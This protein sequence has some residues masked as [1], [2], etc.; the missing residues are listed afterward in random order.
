MS[1][2]PSASNTPEFESARQA[3][4]EALE[5][6]AATSAILSAISDTPNDLQPVFDRIANSA[7]R[8]CRGEF[9]AVFRFDGEMMTLVA[10]YGASPVQVDAWSR[11]FPR[12]PGRDLAIGRAI[13]SREVAAIPDVA[14]DAAFA[15]TY[16]ELANLLNFNSVVAV[17]MLLKGLPIGGIVVTRF[18]K[19]PFP[20]NQIALLKTFAEQAVITI[21]S[22]RLYQELEARTVELTRSVERLTALGEVGRAVTSTLDLEKVL[23]TI[24]S[25]A[26][27]LS[28][29]NSG[30]I[31][32]YDETTE[33]FRV[34]ATYL[35]TPEHLEL[36]QQA[37]IRLGEGAIGRAGLTQEPVEI[38]DTQGT[39]KL[40]A[41]QVRE[42]H[43]REGLR[44][45]FALPLVREEQLLGGLVILRREIREF[46]PEVVGLLRTFADQSVLALHN[47]RLFEK[48]QE[49]N[50]GLSVALAYQTATTGVLRLIASSPGELQPVF[51]RIAESAAQLCRGEFSTVFRFD[52]EIITLVAHHGI[53]PEQVDAWRRTF[54]RPPGRDLAIGRAILT[55]EVAT[56]PNVAEDK[57]LAA[58]Y[59]ELASFVKYRSIV[60]VPMLLKGSPIGGIVVARLEAGPFP[61]NQIDL[62]RT[63][64]D[65][66]VIAIE[67]VRLFREVNRQLEIIRAVFGKYVPDSVA[68]AIVSGEGQLKPIKTT[69]T[70]LFSD[71]ES[72]TSIS[73]DLSPEQVV[74][75]L[76]EY[77][78]TVIEPIR[79]HGGVV[80]QFQGDAM[81]VTFNVPVEDSHHADQAV[82]AAFEIQQLLEGRRFAGIPLRARIGITTGTVVAGNVGSGDRVNY[83]VHGDTVNIAARLEQL[84]KEYRT[85]VLVSGETVSLLTG[86]YPLELIGNASI[87]G[88]QKSIQLYKLGV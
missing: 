39:Q 20:D 26:V 31:Y 77:F 44:S 40:V 64:A 41:P 10:H 45:L 75:M 46:S 5:Q 56:I 32:E 88:K 23:D 81:L 72:F 19:G 30:I 68:E 63:F 79:R 13:L 48:A 18:E 49:S 14:A 33:T 29:S 6:Q 65:Q 24:V 52:G 70:V 83:T 17:P 78:P 76:N 85:R 69:A 9:S 34:R 80:N 36:L 25:R 58:T 4:D 60:A 51:D 15:E 84:N 35:V 42:Q 67:S 61:G 47:A 82:S 16:R 1:R 59:R 62:L 7:V 50:R 37:P 3:L 22:V 66:A 54:P 71:L 53:S 21:E 87:R 73:E 57:L 43:A 12:R 74:S 55:R 86:N 2:R 38:V 28:G 11:T 27:D 8:L